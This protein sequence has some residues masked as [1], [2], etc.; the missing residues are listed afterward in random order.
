MVLFLGNE[1]LNV[2]GFFR[3]FVFRFSIVKVE[4]PNTWVEVCAKLD[5]HPKELPLHL[6][7]ES[8]KII[9]F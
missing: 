5:A 1:I 8:G 3:L 7:T 4:V 6:S 2:V 9:I